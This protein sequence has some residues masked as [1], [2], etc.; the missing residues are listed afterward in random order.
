MGAKAGAQNIPCQS[1]VCGLRKVSGYVR[2]R[3]DG[4]SD[5][6]GGSR[7]VPKKGY[8]YRSDRHLNRAIRS[9]SDP[10]PDRYGAIIS[11]T[12][13]NSMSSVGTVISA[14]RITETSYV[15]EMQ[16]KLHPVFKSPRNN[17]NAVILKVC[18]QHGDNG[19]T[20]CA[21]R[22]KVHHRIRDQLRAA[23]TRVVDPHDM[24]DPIASME[25]VYYD[26]LEA[27]L[28]PRI[29]WMICWQTLFRVPRNMKSRNNKLKLFKVNSSAPY[30]VARHGK[31]CRQHGLLKYGTGTVARLP[32]AYVHFAAFIAAAPSLPK[33]TV[34]SC[35]T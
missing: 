15:F 12:P 29:L 17:L 2:Y 11:S 31:L 1:Q 34:T 33:L 14:H 22:E 3:E 16:Q 6:R 20:S 24:P 26:E 8:K 19:L 28:A 35:K 13:S 32:A 21:K 23:L 27:M 7:R 25:P 9:T 30:P 18:Q 5:D 4:T 10:D